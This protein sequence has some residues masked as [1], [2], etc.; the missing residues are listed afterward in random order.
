MKNACQSFEGKKITLLGL[1]LLGR[2]AGDAEFLAK[3]NARL[4]VTDVKTGVQLAESVERLKKYP[5][6][7]FH[8]GGH[9]K[10]D[11]AN[12]D[13]VIK[14]AG[15]PLNSPEVA[16]AK[17]NNVPVAMSTALFS[18]YAM[19]AGAKVVGVTGTRG[20]STTAQMIYEILKAAGKEVLL[21]GN[22]RGVSTLAM[23]PNVSKNTI[24]ILELD[25]WQL[26]GFGDLKI[27]PNVSVFTNLM[28][29]HLNYYSNS[30][31][32]DGVRTGMEE[33]FSN[34]ANIFR[35]QKENDSLFIGH[36][37][38]ARVWKAKPSTEAV[39]P[40]AIPTDWKLKI[41]GEHNRENA[42][43][44]AAALRALGLSE[45]EIREGLERFE[46]V[47]GRL[48]FVREVN[49][50]KI[51][52]DNNATTPEATVVGLEALSVGQSPGKDITL[53]TGGSE[54]GLPLGK[55]VSSIQE[56]VSHVILLT[57]E[58][59]KGSQRFAKELRE[60]NV[61][62]DEADGLQKAITLA[63]Q[64]TKQGTV[65]FSPGFASFGMFKNEYERNDDF[66]KLVRSLGE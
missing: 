4:I 1:G 59:Y 7:E 43:F 49:G 3:C 60:A 15:V 32:P 55:L 26:Q 57:H 51:Y 54:K 34:K 58:Q 48:Q 45:N 38:A 66:M 36:S 42:S 13:L 27:S 24:A 16:E 10:E 22:V 6:I 11:F 47:E 8:L 19:E 31:T 62:F 5:N 56:N 44:A 52:N 18:K 37:I 35:F 40:P 30:I 17:K 23:L 29:D 61:A 9:R 33:Y 28:P 39:V 25:S 12:A 63:M 20:K 14:A 41:I 65:L 50:I 53:I 21:G 46:G 2:G 64:K